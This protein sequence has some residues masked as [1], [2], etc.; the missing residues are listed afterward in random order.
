[1]FFRGSRYEKAGTYT[2]P[3]ANGAPVL[4]V[5]LPIRPAPAV[6]GFHRRLDA[7]RLD[8]LA[9][10]YQGDAT[11]FWRLC[12]ASGAVSPD[13]LAARDRVAIPVLSGVPA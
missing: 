10:N 5:R 8:L 13:A 3:A 1:M 4:V 7:E 2:V 12:D 6:R 9:A 11:A